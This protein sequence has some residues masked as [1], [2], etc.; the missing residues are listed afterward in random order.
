M[1]DDS[2]NIAELVQGFSK[3]INALKVIEQLGIAPDVTVF[4]ASLLAVIL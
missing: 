3:H 4:N 1:A 2:A